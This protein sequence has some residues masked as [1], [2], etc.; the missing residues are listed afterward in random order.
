MEE[1]Q[2]DINFNYPYSLQT[3]T[4]AVRDY[5]YISN[6]AQPQQ[7]NFSNSKGVTILKSVYRSLI[8]TNRKNKK[9]LKSV[10]YL[11]YIYTYIL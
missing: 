11:Y 8:P 4:S 10:S 3:S 2:Q 9:L 6:K 7:K 5:D 1:P